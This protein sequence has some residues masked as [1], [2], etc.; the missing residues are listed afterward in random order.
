MA[1]GRAVRPPARKKRQRPCTR[2]RQILSSAYSATLLRGRLSDLLEGC[3]PRRL[4]RPKQQSSSIKRRRQLPRLPN[5][6]GRE[7][8]RHAGGGRERG[9]RCP[10]GPGP[11]VP[12]SSVRSHV[13]TPTLWLPNQDFGNGP[14]YR[15]DDEAR[16]RGHG[17]CP[18]P[19]SSPAT[20]TAV[21]RYGLFNCNCS[22]AESM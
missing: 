13:S 1:A 19:P 9:E 4:A 15:T 18:S 6:H 14:R 16:S 22:R 3:V 11:A 20:V 8:L 12:V 17:A 7:V 2:A 21:A 5:H 10:W